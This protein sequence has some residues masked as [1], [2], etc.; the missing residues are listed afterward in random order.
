MIIDRRLLIVKIKVFIFILL[1]T[2]RA[3]RV[4]IIS[5]GDAMQR[6]KIERKLKKAGWTIKPGGKHKM[7]KHPDKPGV[8]IPIPNGSKIDDFTAKGILR[9]AGL[10]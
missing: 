1:F 4:I 5:R 9:D 3:I 2:I 7:A 8:K 6:T 10:Q